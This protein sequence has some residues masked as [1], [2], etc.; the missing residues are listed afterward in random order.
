MRVFPWAVDSMFDPSSGNG[1]YIPDT[2]TIEEPAELVLFEEMVAG[3]GTLSITGHSGSA[4]VD[5][6]TLELTLEG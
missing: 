1:I 2:W 3:D 6:F 4:E 5:P